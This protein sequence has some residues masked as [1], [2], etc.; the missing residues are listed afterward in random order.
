MATFQLLLLFVIEFHYSVDKGILDAGSQLRILVI[1]WMIQYVLTDELGTSWNFTLCS[2][3][4]EIE[5][6]LDLV[7]VVRT[8]IFDFHELSNQVPE[9]GKIALL[10]AAKNFMYE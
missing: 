2:G 6:L 7:L 4:K 8:V 5:N 9:T 10:F 3:H 1:K